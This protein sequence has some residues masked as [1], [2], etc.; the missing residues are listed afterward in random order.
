VEKVRS[1][2]EEAITLIGK[3]QELANE[4]LKDDAPNFANV[5]K[6]LEGITAALKEYTLHEAPAETPQAAEQQ[7]TSAGVPAAA[8]SAPGTVASRADVVRTLNSV[9]AY[10]TANEPSSPIPFLLE[11]AKQ[12]VNN[13]F[14]GVIRN[15]RPDL[16]KDFLSL[17]G[18]NQVDGGKPPPPS[19]QGQGASPSTASCPT[20]GK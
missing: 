20:A 13:D 7:G 3:L 17:L 10:Y 5:R 14:F 9:I 11:R 2:V 6:E 18:A 19:G 12:L 1:D 15:F 4:R 16:E 8:V